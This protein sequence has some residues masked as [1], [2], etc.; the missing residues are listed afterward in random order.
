V[1]ILASVVEREVSKKEDREIVAGILLKRLKNEW[2]LDADATIQYAVGVS[3]NWWPSSLKNA[4]LEINSPF[5]SRKNKGLPPAP[6]CNPSI[7][8]IEAVYAYRESP[9]WFYLDGSDGT[10]Y[11][12]E[13]LEKH[14]ENIATHL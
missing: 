8:A 5:N 10:T 9:Y 4:D 11:F 12:A 2:P 1:V 6:I 13:T 14:N 7:S 3:K